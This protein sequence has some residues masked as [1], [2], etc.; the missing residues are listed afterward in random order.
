MHLPELTIHGQ[1]LAYVNY[2]SGSTGAA[3]GIGISHH[4]LQHYIASA[5]DFIQLESQD[6]VLQ[7]ATANFDAF[8]EQVFPT[9]A[10]GATLVLRDDS[11][12]SPD[13]LYQQAQQHQISVMDLSA[14]YWRAVA[15]NWAQRAAVTGRL[16]LPHLRQVHSGGEAMSVGDK[17][18]CSTR[19]SRLISR[20]LPAKEENE[21]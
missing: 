3:K 4:A 17:S 7:F 10:V 2:T 16:S 1:Q 21:A 12:W 15:A 11:L 13:K 14:A 8:V 18:P 5:I 6:V 9:W 19:L 20:G